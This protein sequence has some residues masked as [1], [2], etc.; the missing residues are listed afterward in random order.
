MTATASPDITF[1]RLRIGVSSCLLGNAVRYGNHAIVSLAATQRVLRFTVE[2]DGPGID[3]DAREAVLGRGKR[4]DESLEGHGIGLAIAREIVELYGGKLSL[5]HS[6][7]LGGLRVTV[8]L[9]L[10][11]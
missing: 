2:D 7:E 11:Q 9:P 8:E 1:P 3:S 5:A 4:L 6:G 10:P